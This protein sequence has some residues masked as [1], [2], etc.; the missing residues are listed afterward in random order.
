MSCLAAR[1]NPLT[2]ALPMP[3][4]RQPR[5]ET[6]SSV[7]ADSDESAPTDNSEE[8]EYAEPPRQP[9]FATNATP[10]SKEKVR[11]MRARVAKGESPFHPADLDLRKKEVK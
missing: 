7:R 3:S 4:R 10:G 5:P 2:A 6:T 8:I 11:I 9:T 1:P